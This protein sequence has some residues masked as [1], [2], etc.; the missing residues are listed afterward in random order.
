M[1]EEKD[2]KREEAAGSLPQEAP[3]PE[4]E[5]IAPEGEAAA[6][7]YR[8]SEEEIRESLYAAGFLKKTLAGDI[9]KTALLLFLCVVF[10][11]QYFISSKNYGMGIF[12]IAVCIAVGVAVWILPG[13]KRDIAAEKAKTTEQV[14]LAVYENLLVYETGETRREYPLNGDCALLCKGDMLLFFAT[15]GRLIVIPGR[16][17]SSP[18]DWERAKSRL[19]NGTH[20]RAV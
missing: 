1:Q 8:L 7:S 20:P 13:K 5:H 15:G 16:A 9:I 12:L 2:R 11:Q 14:S 4:A 18:E 6:A 3:Q 10:A 17:F 19:T